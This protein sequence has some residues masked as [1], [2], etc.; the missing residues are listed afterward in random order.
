MVKNMLIATGAYFAVGAACAIGYWA[1][2]Y[3]VDFCVNKLAE[4]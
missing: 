4:N 2:Y 1:G 3:L